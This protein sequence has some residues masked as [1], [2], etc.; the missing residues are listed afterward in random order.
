MSKKDSWLK[1]LSKKDSRLKELSK[2]DLPRSKPKDNKLSYK[3]KELSKP[4]LNPNSDS[5]QNKKKL[6]A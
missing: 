1:K 6:R 4:D 5:K 2:K 3:N